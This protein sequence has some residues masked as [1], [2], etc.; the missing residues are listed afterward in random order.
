MNRWVLVSKACKTSGLCHLPFLRGRHFLRRFLFQPG[1]DR[2]CSKPS[3]SKSLPQW[4][5]W[6]AAPLTW[7]SIDVEEYREEM[8]KQTPCSLWSHR[9]E[10]AWLL[11]SWVITTHRMTSLAEHREW[12][13]VNMWL[14]KILSRYWKSHTT[15]LQFHRTPMSLCAYIY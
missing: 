10:A 6:R 8:F 12:G 5:C 1:Q 9:V 14:L 3:L 7:R 4:Q 2:S 11:S 15:T 13:W